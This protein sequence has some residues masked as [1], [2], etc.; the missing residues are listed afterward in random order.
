MPLKNKFDNLPD[1]VSQSHIHTARLTDRPRFWENKYL[2]DP[3]TPAAPSTSLPK[4]GHQDQFE[5]PF[6][7]KEPTRSAEEQIRQL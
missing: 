4:V 7:E 5:T 1:S 6:H 3:K 2:I